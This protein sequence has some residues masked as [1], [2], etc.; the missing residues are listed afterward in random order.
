MEVFLLFFI[1]LLSLIMLIIS[2]KIMCWNCRGIL[3][4]ET[5]TRVLHLI[6]SHRP[7]IVCLVK[8][9]ANSER[10]DCFCSKIPRHWEWAALLA[11]GYSGGIIVMWNKEFGHVALFAVNKALHLIIS[12]YPS[13]IFIISIIYNSNRLYSQHSL[14][15]ELSRLTNFNFPWLLIGDF[16]TIVNRNEHKGGLLRYYSHI[17]ISFSEFINANNLIDHN[18]SRPKFT[19]CINQSGATRWWARLD[20]CLVNSG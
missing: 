16:N 20:R 5:F 6:R 7:V 1:H 11:N 3:A 12:P 8:T 17:A 18:F 4:Y 19:W 13:S 14:S 10:V 2:P 15:L 9:R